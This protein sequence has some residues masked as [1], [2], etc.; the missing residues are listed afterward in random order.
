M[1]LKSKLYECKVGHSR[2]S[3]KKHNFSYKLFTFY[4]DLD[5][6]EKLNQFLIFFS[7]AK[8]N[9]FSFYT[10]DHFAKY[11]NNLKESIIE[12]AKKEGHKGDIEKITLLTHT[13]VLGYTFNP[14]CF[15]FLFNNENKAT[16]SVIEVHN[17]FGEMK[18]F[19]VP[20]I[21]DNE[22]YLKSKKYFYVSPFFNLNTEFEFSLKLPD[23]K[24]EIQIDDLEDNKKVFYSYYKGKQL[25][26]NDLNL[27]KLFFKYPFVTIGIIL[28][29]HL[30][31]LKLYMKKIPFIRKIENPDLQRGV[32]VGKNS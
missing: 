19:Y 30:Q 6:L 28:R 11:G 12:F 5:E 14:V 10:K 23:N 8:F 17:T 29:I 24:L 20:L 27:L 22:F 13:R 1:E 32:Y 18:P 3:P 7:V 2:T 16:A 26:L 4:L 31:A 21:S 9:L 15:Y 25:E